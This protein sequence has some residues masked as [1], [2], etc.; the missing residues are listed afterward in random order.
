[1]QYTGL[2]DKN[3]VEIFEGDRIQ[4]EG[5]LYEVYFNMGEYRAAERPPNGKSTILSDENSSCEV[6]GN[7][8]QHPSLISNKR[9][10][11]K[12]EEAL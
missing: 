12:R 2:K 6:I 7:I 8:Y 11:E 3:G 1:M 9:P 4:S 10:N 5:I